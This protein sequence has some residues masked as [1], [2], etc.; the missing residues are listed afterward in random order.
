MCCIK[1]KKTAIIFS[2]SLHISFHFFHISLPSPRVQGWWAA[3][4]QLHSHFTGPLSQVTLEMFHLSHHPWF[5]QDHDRLATAVTG[6][7]GKCV[8]LCAC[9]CACSVRCLF[10]LEKDSGKMKIDHSWLKAEKNK[11]VLLPDS[12]HA[13][14]SGWQRWRCTQARSRAS[15][16]LFPI[17]IFIRL[18]IVCPTYHCER[19]ELQWLIASL[20]LTALVRMQRYQT[21]ENFPIV[22]LQFLNGLWAAHPLMCLNESTYLPLTTLWLRSLYQMSNRVRQCSGAQYP[23][24]CS[25]GPFQ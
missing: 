21:N 14:L 9:V 12:Q 8:S 24:S 18:A 2:S 7:P 20:N 3:A 1:K 6:L 4:T 5:F 19:A 22:W 13:C 11:S 23:L 17:P 16:L 10:I 25:V 15:P